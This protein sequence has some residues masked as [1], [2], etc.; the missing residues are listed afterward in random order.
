[1]LHFLL[2]QRPFFLAFVVPVTAEYLADRPEPQLRRLRHE[3][4]LVRVQQRSR[5]QPGEQSCPAVVD[6][7]V[8]HA[9]ED[10]QHSQ[11]LLLAEIGPGTL[12]GGVAADHS[13]SLQPCDCIAQISVDPDAAFQASVMKAQDRKR[14]PVP[15]HLLDRRAPQPA[16]SMRHGV[17]GVGEY[18]PVGGPRGRVDGRQRHRHVSLARAPEARA[19]RYH[20]RLQRPLA[21]RGHP[22]APPLRRCLPPGALAP[23]TGEYQPALKGPSRHSASCPFRCGRTTGRGR[24]RRGPGGPLA[25]GKLDPPQLVWELGHRTLPGPG[26]GLGPIKHT[27]VRWPVAVWR[28]SVTLPCDHAWVLIPDLRS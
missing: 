3:D 14:P 11:V 6:D 10:F 16:V 26:T 9:L 28:V 2:G 8:G 25:S 7:N 15:R 17:I 27:P 1:M 5:L 20:A 13:H 4:V 24:G 19:H 18:H 22:L 23:A 12:I 21:D